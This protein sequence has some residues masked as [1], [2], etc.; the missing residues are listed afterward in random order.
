M[1][2]RLSLKMAHLFG[3]S[4]ASMQGSVC[5]EG[6]RARGQTTVVMVRKE[7]EEVHDRTR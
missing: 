1:I 2:K 3:H 5:V 4:E 7:E 6:E